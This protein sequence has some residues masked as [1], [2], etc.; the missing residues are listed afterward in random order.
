M[1]STGNRSFSRYCLLTISSRSLADGRKLLMRLTGSWLNGLNSSMW[2]QLVRR[3]NATTLLTG[4]LTTPV[5]DGAEI[6]IVPAV[7]GGVAARPEA[8]TGTAA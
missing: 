4:G 8:R 6:S 3:P 1:I 5:H 2:Q 7:S